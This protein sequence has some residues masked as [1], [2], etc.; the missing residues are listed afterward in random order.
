MTMNYRSSY[1]LEG[2]TRDQAVRGL[3]ELCRPCSPTVVKHFVTLQAFKPFFDNDPDRISIV[4][5]L[6]YEDIKDMPEV[7]VVLALDDLRQHE[8]KY[9]PLG[10]VVKEVTYYRDMIYD[11]LDYFKGEN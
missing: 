2:Q 4:Y 10:D 11:A 6:L 9:F 3:V 1:H 8:S 5:D 7:A